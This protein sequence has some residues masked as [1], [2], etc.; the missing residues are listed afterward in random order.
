LTNKYLI[1]Q[2]EIIELFDNGTNYIEISR[3]LIDKYN[4]EVSVD[5]LRKQVKD[6]VHYVVADKEIVQYNVRL[7]KQKQKLQDLNRISNKS[8]REDSR[9]ENALVEYNKE[10]IKL[11]KKE[12]IDVK[13]KR[14]KH[15]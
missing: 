5:Y 14:Q 3:F 12:S 9:L 7:A 8:F 4:L 13:L 10:L 11:L 2:D 1:Y 15:D 6:I